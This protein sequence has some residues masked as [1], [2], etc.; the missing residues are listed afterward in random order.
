MKAHAVN[1]D[2]IREG[3]RAALRN[4]PHEP[5]WQPRIPSGVHRVLWDDWWRGI[6]MTTEACGRAFDAE[7]AETKRRW[8]GGSSQLAELLSRHQATCR[9]VLG[10]QETRDEGV[11]LHEDEMR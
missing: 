11:G 3:G 8:S 1:F 7:T 5:T 4:Y 9:V 2:A 6:T 10:E